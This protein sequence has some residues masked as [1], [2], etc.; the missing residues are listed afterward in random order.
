MKCTA[1]IVTYFCYYVPVD[2]YRTFVITFL[3]GCYVLGDVTILEM[4]PS[5][6]TVLQ[7]SASNTES[8]VSRLRSV[9]VGYATAVMACKCTPFTNT[10]LSKVYR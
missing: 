3:R 9:I 2:L 6:K 7:S 4:V 5:C 10:R 1:L 8:R